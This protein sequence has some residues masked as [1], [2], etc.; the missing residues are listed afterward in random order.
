MCECYCSKEC[1]FIKNI[2]LQNLYALEGN[3][4]IYMRNQK[5]YK[6][7]HQIINLKTKTH[8]ITYFSYRDLQE[9][10]TKKQ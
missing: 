8:C 1:H 7:N 5:N 4:H 10:K 9:K 2:I 6:K 3:T